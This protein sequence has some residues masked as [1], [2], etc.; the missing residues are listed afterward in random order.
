MKKL[1]PVAVDRTRHIQLKPKLLSHLA[2][3]RLKLR[4]ARFNLTTRQSPEDKL[5]IHP[6]HHKSNQQN[7]SGLI[8]QHNPAVRLF[9]TLLR[10]PSVSPQTPPA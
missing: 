9:R 6:R 3:R 7:L 2:H 5:P 4:F 1:I 8:K 10:P